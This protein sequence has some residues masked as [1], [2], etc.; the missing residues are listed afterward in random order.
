MPRKD[1]RRSRNDAGGSSVIAQ[2]EADRM[3]ADRDAESMLSS[4][5]DMF[6]TGDLTEPLQSGSGTFYSLTDDLLGELSAP[7]P[8][9]IDTEVLTARELARGRVGTAKVKAAD[10]ANAAVSEDTRTLPGTG[11]SGHW[12]LEAGGPDFL[13]LPADG[14]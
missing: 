2:R 9:E 1:D 3:F 8:G 4:P 7:I 13:D 10:A 5:L 11:S 14:V 12:L 6:N